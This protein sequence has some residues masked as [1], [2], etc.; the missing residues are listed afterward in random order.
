MPP[1]ARSLIQVLS[2]TAAAAIATHPIVAQNQQQRP[3]FRS[4]VNFITVDAYPLID[5]KVVEGLTIDDFE[6]LEDGR[7][8]RVESFDF[9]RADERM[10]SAERRDPRSQSEMLEQ[11]Q[12]PQSRAFVAYLDVHHVGLSGAFYSREP[13]IE[14]FQRILAPGDLI[15]LATS[16]NQPRALT[17]GRTTDVVE[18][19]LRRHWTWRDPDVTVNDAEELTL[20]GS[21][22]PFAGI[23]DELIARRR[24]DQLL[25]NLEGTV[26]YLGEIREGRKTLFLFSRGWELYAPS[27]ELLKPFSDPNYIPSTGPPITSAPP[28]NLPPGNGPRPNMRLST[29]LAEGSRA[30]C[31]QEVTRLADLDTR[32]RFRQL[33]N[34]ARANN[35]V[36][37]PVNPAGV[38]AVGDQNDRLLELAS[39]TGGTAVYNRNDLLEG[40]INVSREFAAY[41]LLGYASDNPATDGRLRRIEVKVRRPGVT[42]KA[43][44]GYRALSMAEAASKA[45][46]LATPIVIDTARAEVDAALDTLA[47]VRPTDALFVHPARTAAGIAVAVELAAGRAGPAWTVDVQATNASTGDVRVARGR[48]AAGG[49]HADII[50]RGA[51]PSERWHVTARARGDADEIVEGSADTAAAAHGGVEDVRVFR[52]RPAGDWT[53]AGQLLFA[54]SERA[55]FEGGLGGSASSAQLRVLDR[56]GAVVP[57]QATATVETEPA[58]AVGELTM[59]ALAPGDYVAELTVGVDGEAVRRLV[60]FRVVR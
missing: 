59:A 21:C 10:T 20:F 11:L 5:G 42:V 13:L 51:A 60:A 1:V 46:V 18:E 24:Q 33:I 28:P 8:Q 2:I 58:R 44:Q 55:R 43:R 4:D 47:R 15:A 36:I 9:V 16:Q 35:V 56:T 52:R 12:D 26:E 41:Y 40:V 22:Y 6:V 32:Q 57:A 25:A 37:Y 19:Q 30:A 45:A 29:A 14:L 53:P 31:E 34:D 54:R 23:G 48:I 50:V 49:R 27:R 38:G 3:V 17:F 39:G 7:P